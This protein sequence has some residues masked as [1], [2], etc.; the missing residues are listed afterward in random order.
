MFSRFPRH[1]IKTSDS[2]NFRIS[3]VIS[4]SQSAK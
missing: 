4:G 1:I 2:R 3:C